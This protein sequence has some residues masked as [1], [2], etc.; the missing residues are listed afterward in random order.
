[1]TDD[2]DQIA[3]SARLPRRTQKT[4]VLVVEGGTLNKAGEVLAFS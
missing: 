3:L 4:A 1:M 2:D